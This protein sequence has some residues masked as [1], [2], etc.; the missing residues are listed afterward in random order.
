MSKRRKPRIISASEHGIDRSVVSRGAQ[1]T[2]AGLT[3]AGFRAEMV[4]GCVR[5]LLRG[6]SPKDFDIS[7]NARPE[8][9]REL[10][11]SSRIIGRRFL[12]VQVGISGEFVEITTYRMMP[13]TANQAG[14][15]RTVS[16]QG[17]ILRDNRFG[18]ID[19]DAFRRDFTMNA[20]YLRASD[21]AILD[22]VNGYQDIQD[23]VIRTIGKPSVRFREDPVRM[24]RAIRFA[25]ALDF[26]IEPKTGAAIRPLSHMLED[27]PRARLADELKK[28]LF[29]G[30]A[31]EFFQLSMRFGLFSRLFPVYSK[32]FSNATEPAAVQLINLLFESMDMRFRSGETLSTAYTFATILWPKFK[33]FLH[34]VPR[35][36]KPIQQRGTRVANQILSTQAARIHIPPHYRLRILE[37]WE[38]QQRLERENPSSSGVYNHRCFRAALRLFTLRSKIDEVDS[39]VAE[40]WKIGQERRASR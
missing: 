1:L 10:F 38:L 36:K 39:K 33:Q 35:S 9:V 13:N 37:I 15:R 27:I 18:T 28:L 8:Q 7:T 25:A 21:F 22:Y 40:Q 26:D 34:H 16:R 31:Q 20:L 3:E 4:G 5:D 6:A 30:Y 29:G 11:R 17:R 19:Q 12:I 32:K 14:G 2:L 24:L 23:R